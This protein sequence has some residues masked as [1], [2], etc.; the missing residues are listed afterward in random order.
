MGLCCFSYIL[1]HLLRAV[2]KP[3]YA[4]SSLSG[5][6]KYITSKCKKMH[7]FG[8]NVL[9]EIQHIPKSK[10]KMDYSHNITKHTQESR[11]YLPLHR[12]LKIWNIIFFLKGCCVLWFCGFFS[13]I[14]YFILRK[15][16]CIW[17]FKHSYLILSGSCHS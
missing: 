1:P 17:M 2:L 5:Q 9:R 13:Y 4:G 12:C 6:D 15:R 14:A 3:Q 10:F 7:N 16:C 8:C 11:W